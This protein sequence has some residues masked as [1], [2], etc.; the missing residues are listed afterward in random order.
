LATGR[1]NGAEEE[2]PLQ[3]PD[4]GEEPA[5]S[6]SIKTT[7]KILA[8]QRCSRRWGESCQGGGCF[9]D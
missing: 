8:G 3:G 5:S 2:L 7:L 9:A 1:I 6:P 4:D